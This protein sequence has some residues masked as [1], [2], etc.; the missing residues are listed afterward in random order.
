MKTKCAFL[1]PDFDVVANRGAAGSSG[2]VA[3]PSSIGSGLRLT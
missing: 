3:P 2:N 1:N